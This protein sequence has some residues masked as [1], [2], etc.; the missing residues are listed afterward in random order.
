MKKIT[1]FLTALAMGF[2][3]NSQA[4]ELPASPFTG[5]EPGTIENVYLYNVA[6]GMFLGT[7]RRD[8]AFWTT[9]AQ[10]DS[11]GID[12][13]LTASGDGFVINPKLGNN[14][15]MNDFNLYL[16]T[17]QPATEWVFT[18]V[19]A[20][21]KT[22]YALSH[23][24]TSADATKGGDWIVA[25]RNA[26]GNDN[27]PLITNKADLALENGNLWQIITTAEMMQYLATATEENP[28]D[29]SFL[30][31]DADFAAN[32][33]YYSAWQ[34]LP[35]TNRDV[36]ADNLVNCNRLQ[37]IWGLTELDFYQEL[38][39]IPNGT[40]VLSAN[41]CYNSTG[42]NGINLNNFNAYLDKTNADVKGVIYMGEEETPMIH[43]YSLALDAQATYCKK[44]L[45]T[46]YV[47]G[48]NG[49]VSAA[50]YY[51]FF[52][53]E[54]ITVNVTD[55]T[56]RLGAKVTEGTGTSWVLLD[57][58]T[59]TYKGDTGTGISE[60]PEADEAGAIADGKIYNL[61]GMEVSST[62]QPGFYIINGK[63]VLK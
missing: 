33:E 26:N 48:G 57:N 8:P 40:Y 17:A 18:P 36:C 59:L 51:G 14:N 45:G 9:R 46:H 37:E 38:T 2:A 53:T 29:A 1:L 31:K 3:A 50:F 15:S 47:P 41:A 21:G 49:Q 44:Q 13:N 23:T 42:Q 62:A 6:S 5:V 25:A 12:V 55:G 22:Y 32:S 61:Q 11:R 43:L 28:I 7:N 4:Q 30:V 27:L 63:T 39:G 20:N 54:P 60:A 52:R 56:L 24:N 35:A 10:L 34:G 16:D 19:S 58:F